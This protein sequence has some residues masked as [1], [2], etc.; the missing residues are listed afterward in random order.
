MT[1]TS[2]KKNVV[3]RI[4]GAFIKID[5]NGILEVFVAIILIPN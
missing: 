4:I 1:F 3:S 5:G 2:R